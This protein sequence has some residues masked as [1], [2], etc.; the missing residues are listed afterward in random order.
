[1]NKL[2]QAAAWTVIVGLGAGLT[3]CGGD[4]A[5]NKDT[6][7]NGPKAV[8]AF[9]LPNKLNLKLFASK[10]PE[11]GEY[12]D[13]KV[14]KDLEQKTNIHIDWTLVTDGLQ[15]KKNLLFA[16]NDL[17]DAFYGPVLNDEDIVKYGTQGQ[18]IPLEKL[19]DQYAPNIKKVLEAKPEMKKQITAPDG[20]IYYIPNLN[21]LINNI[22]PDVLYVNKTWLDKLGMKPP[23]TTDEFYAML[24]AFQN[25]DLNGNGKNDEIPFSFVFD[26]VS[27]GTDQLAGAFGVTGRKPDNY[28]MVKDGKVLFA[29]AQPEYKQYIAFMN[30]L[31]S[32]KLID[33]EAFTQKETVFQSKVKSKEL[34]VGAGYY[35]SNNTYFGKPDSD[36][37][38]IPPLKG[39]SGQR[40]YLQRNMPI[41]KAFSITSVNKSPEATMKWLD[42]SY[43]TKASLEVGYGPFGV[44][45]TEDASGKISYLPTPQGMGY[46]VFRHKDAPGSAGAYVVLKETLDKMESNEQTIEKTKHYEMLKPYFAK[47]IYPDLMFSIADRQ[48]MS[49]YQQ[50]IHSLVQNTIP[51]WVINGNFNAEWDAYIAQMKKMGL[52]DMM[53]IY[54]KYYDESKKK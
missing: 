12:N 51:K 9:P 34:V 46:A 36:Y 48:R 49:T 30:K 21:E 22:V 19:I 15:E 44:N 35:F 40:F 47:E 42:L 17:P 53:K 4:S 16:S 38:P 13:M 52:D 29:P 20:H 43:N 41:G 1:M 33:P 3:G 2:R 18:I 6:S 26:I 45:L 8:E 50:D 54:Q 25:K 31:Y 28:L 39:P 24:K 7:S 23:E 37:I 27:Q 32:E 14:F 5:A 11:A 10:R